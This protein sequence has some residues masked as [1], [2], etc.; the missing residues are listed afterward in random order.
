[1][2]N[3]GHATLE[4]IGLHC[5]QEFLHYNQ[6]EIFLG[7]LFKTMNVI[8]NADTSVRTPLSYLISLL[9]SPEYANNKILY[10]NI[11][12]AIIVTVNSSKI[13]SLKVS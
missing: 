1:M 10:Y 7:K 11:Y 13:T 8:I 5:T 3:V 9:F 4:T 6:N 12:S 2:L